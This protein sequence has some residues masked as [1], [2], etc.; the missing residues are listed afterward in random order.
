MR[1]RPQKQGTSFDFR[2]D[3][4]RKAGRPKR[5][6]RRGCRLTLAR[7]ASSVLIHRGTQGMS[8]MQPSRDAVWLVTVF[9]LC[10]CAPAAQCAQGVE[11]ASD[12][13]PRTEARMLAPL[14]D[15]SEFGAGVPIRATVFDSSRL[16]R[17]NIEGLASN[18]GAVVVPDP[19][20][21]GDLSL[22]VVDFEAREGFLVDEQ[23]NVVPADDPTALSFSIHAQRGSSNLNVRAHRGRIHATFNS[24]GGAFVAD[25]DDEAGAHVLQAVDRAILNASRCAAGLERDDAGASTTA[26]RFVPTLRDAGRTTAA[27]HAGAKN[28]T[29]RIG[30]LVA[31]TPQAL[32]QAGSVSSLEATADAAIEQTNR[33]LADSGQAIYLRLERLGGAVDSGINELTAQQQPIASNRFAYVRNLSRESPPIASARNAVGADIVVTLVADEGNPTAEPPDPFYGIAFTQ[34]PNCQPGGFPTACSPG[35]NYVS[36]A[37]AVVSRPF[38]TLNYTFAHEIGH[39]L[40]AE[41][42]PRF[43][44]GEGL[45]S[46]L[47]SYGHRVSQVAMD[48]M[49]DPTCITPNPQDPVG[50]PLICTTKFLQY[51]NP[52][53]PFV[54]TQVASGTT[55]PFIPAIDGNRTRDVALTF[56][57]LATGTSNLLGGLEPDRLSWDGFE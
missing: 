2:I 35:P 31:Y 27:R 38:A 45:A 26:K 3:A 23:G 1:R 11:S 57:K 22:P 41:H 4:P 5:L 55:T 52:T 40:G 34:R 43:G 32:T 47:H 9:A 28:P 37:F 29:F 33:A 48:I 44:I 21:R 39:T 17:P 15:G 13:P 6:P 24:E 14:D 12:A 42:E 51:A 30:V 36:Y 56:R 50:T 18:P 54:G 16:V 49:A 20:G 7:G 25:F 19:V 10:F 46:F 8:E 53:L